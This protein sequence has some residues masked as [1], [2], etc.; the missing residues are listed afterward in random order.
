[1]SS[2]ISVTNPTRS[3]TFRQ[4]TVAGIDTFIPTREILPAEA[5]EIGKAVLEDGLRLASRTEVGF[6]AGKDSGFHKEVHG[7]R[8]ITATANT[9]LSERSY[10]EQELPCDEHNASMWQDVNPS[11]SGLVVLVPINFSV[12]E[13]RNSEDCGD[14][15]KGKADAPK[16]GPKEVIRLLRA[17]NIANRV[18]D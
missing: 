8:I 4:V 1:M 2:T 6:L 17:L 12:D 9:C 10:D 13:L 5:K 7:R 15:G 14:I 16:A 11:S 18:E 3:I